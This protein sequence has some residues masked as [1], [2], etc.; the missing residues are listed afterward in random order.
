[1]HA[2]LDRLVLVDGDVADAGAADVDIVE[3]AA[4]TGLGSYRLAGTVTDIDVDVA[5]GAGGELGLEHGVEPDRELHGHAETVALGEPVGQRGRA[6]GVP[7]QH[8]GLEP[9]GLDVS[10][11][12]I[13]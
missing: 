4:E 12:L 6:R 1:D 10:R 8:D 7:D 2:A 11:S 3:L 13:G 9:A 5:L